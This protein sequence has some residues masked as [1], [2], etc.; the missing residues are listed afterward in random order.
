MKV[1]WFCS[2]T[3][4]KCPNQNPILNLLNI[5]IFK[6]ITHKV[7]TL[8]SKSSVADQRIKRIKS[9]SG[10]LGLE[11]KTFFYLE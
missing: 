1:V 5:S 3:L 11:K 7:K 6:G 9:F 2:S 8:K 10:L 4:G